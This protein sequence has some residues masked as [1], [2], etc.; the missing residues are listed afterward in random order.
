MADTKTYVKR[1]NGHYVKDEEARSAA[2]AAQSTANSAQATANEAK[3]GLSGKQDTLSFDGTYNASTNKVATVSTVT[4]KI[5]AVVASAPADYDTLKEIAD[6][7]ASDK[8]G[9]AQLSNTVAQNTEDIQA[10]SAD[11]QAI[12][13][14]LTPV[15]SATNATKLNGQEASYYLNYNNF[16]N[17]PTSLKNPTSLT[18]GIVSN[19]T[20]TT[21]TYDGSTARTIGTQTLPVQY[22]NK[23]TRDASGNIIA[24]TYAK[25]ASPTFTGTPNAPTAAAGTNTTQIATTAFVYTGLSTLTNNL[26]T[27]QINLSA[28]NFATK[29]E[30][31]NKKVNITVSNEEMTIS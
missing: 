29:T 26:T 30:L 11:I 9:A 4:T 22:A 5:A 28:Y 17:K 6:Y 15:G 23:A 18:L 16:T 2:A 14:G 3:S 10:A 12:V 1:I 7:I 27:A 8:T 19:G 31:E 25:L 24:D 21:Q 20:E 13:E